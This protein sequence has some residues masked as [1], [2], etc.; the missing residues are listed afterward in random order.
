M[1]TNIVA[2]FMSLLMLVSCATSTEEGATG[3]KRKQLLAVSSEEIVDASVKGYEHTK[4]EAQK[5][6]LLDKNPAQYQRVSNIAKQLIPFT[7]IFRKDALSWKWE[8]H[9]ITSPELNAYCMPGGKMMFYSGIIEKL[10]LTDG[11]IA[12]I[13]GHE[14]A[15][16]LREHG[17]ERMSEQ[18]VTQTATQGGLAIL[19]ATGVVD[20]KYAGVAA[21]GASAFTQLFISLPH[22]RTQ[23][24]EADTMGV[25]LMARA[26]YDPREAVSLWKKMGSQGGSKPPEILS[27]H[28]TDSTRIK[29]IEGLL[30]KVMPLYEQAK[31]K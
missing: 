18:M 21:I 24:S 8:V 12:A 6:G 25:E 11:E 31:Q 5:K 3:V 28:P 26:G 22:G 15:H 7:P 16:A 17:R 23:E 14:M 1:E 30:P 13:M 4:Q 29:D 10:Q 20:P 9:V 27:T 2:F 19:V